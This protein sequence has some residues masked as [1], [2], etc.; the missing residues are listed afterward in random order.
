LIGQKE[1]REFLSQ[2]IE[3]RKIIWEVFLGDVIARKIS[4]VMV[5]MSGKIFGYE[6]AIKILMNIYD[7]L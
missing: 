7:E 2:S 5:G 4:R 6:R 3:Q 1:N